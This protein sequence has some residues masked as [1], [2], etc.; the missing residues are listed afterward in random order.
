[1]LYCVD[2]KAELLRIVRELQS[3]DVLFAV[4]RK[5]RKWTGTAL[6][7]RGEAPPLV[8]GEVARIV[9]WSGRY[10]RTIRRATPTRPRSFTVDSE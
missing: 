4:L 2:G 8:A 1:M 5:A 10:D 9:S 6:V 7:K 3:D